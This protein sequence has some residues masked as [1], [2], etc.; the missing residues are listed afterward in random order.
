MGTRVGYTGGTAKDPNYKTVCRGDGHTEA[1]QITFN[2]AEVSYDTLLDVF[3]SEHLPIRK[4][5]PQ[6]KSAV[7]THNEEQVKLIQSKIKSL[8]A[9]KGLKIVTDV[10]KAKEWYDAE[11]YH[12]KYIEK[13]NRGRW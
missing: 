2:P 5:K 8:E 9:S 13:Q 4:T 3:F 11:E 12:Q 1:I 6:Y 10:E 7:Y